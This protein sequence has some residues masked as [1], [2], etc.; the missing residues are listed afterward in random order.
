[1]TVATILSIS[2]ILVV[3]N[4]LITVNQITKTSVDKLADKIN[5][6]IYLNDKTTNENLTDIKEF[7]DK[8]NY[9]KNSTIVTKENALSE[10]KELYPDTVEFLDEFEIENPLPTSIKVLT[11][12]IEDHERIDA[13]IYK[14]KYKDLILRS[15]VKNQYNNTI[16]NVV[17][18]LIKIKQFSI[19]ILLWI[20]IT[21]ITAGGLIIFNA[22][23]TTLYTRRSEI[24]IMQFVGATFRKIMMPFIYE[25]AILGLLSFL[26][27]IILMTGMS[28]LLPLQGLQDTSFFTIPNIAKILILEAVI[29]LSIGILTS[30]HAV[31]NYLNSKEI[32]DA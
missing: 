14:S 22:L 29:A 11:K 21:F 30:L 15:E 24:Q 5:Y 12:T 6:V 25:G 17:E 27:S 18:N 32:F 16:K 2:L 10:I 31:N 7:I 19:Q 3:F 23:K 20:I 26:L 13:E 8:F 9:T 1:M 4:V 28:Q